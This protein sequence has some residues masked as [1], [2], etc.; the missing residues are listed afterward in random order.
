M[1]SINTRIIATILAAV[2]LTASVN[3]AETAEADS[4][5][6]N[7]AGPDTAEMNRDLARQANNVAVEDAI[8]AVLFANKL[9]LDIRI[10]GRTSAYTSEEPV[11]GR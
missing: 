7:P 10:N 8:E 4:A 5:T 11:D 2:L 9:N 6:D 1:Q 3:A